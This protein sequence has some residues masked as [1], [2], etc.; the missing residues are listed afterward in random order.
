ML[1][2]TCK[3]GNTKENMACVAANLSGDNCLECPQTSPDITLSKTYGPRWTKIGGQERHQGHN[4]VASQVQLGTQS[5]QDEQ[6]FQG[7]KEKNE[8]CY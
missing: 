4:R 5:P 1:Q 2:L 3:T 8:A 7:Y 6:A